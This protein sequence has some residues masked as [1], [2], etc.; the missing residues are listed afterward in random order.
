V[1]DELKCS[2]GCGK[3]FTHA[4][5]MTKHAVHCPGKVSTRGRIARLAAR[6]H[7]RAGA[8]V[9]ARAPKVKRARRTPPAAHE[10]PATEIARPAPSC[11]TCFHAPVCILRAKI[12]VFETQV[13]GLISESIAEIQGDEQVPTVRLDASCSLYAA[14]G[15]DGAR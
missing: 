10:C 8:A 4:G 1:A 3:T 15:P 9:K 11:A 6:H 14:G 12:V 5:W 7:P 13:R 2:A